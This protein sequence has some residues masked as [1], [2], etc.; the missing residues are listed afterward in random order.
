MREAGIA[1]AA[2]ACFQRLRELN[3]RSWIAV[4][5]AFLLSLQSVK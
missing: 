5:R 2:I 3:L 4:F 1:V